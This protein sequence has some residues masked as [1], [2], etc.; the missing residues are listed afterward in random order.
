MNF[1]LICLFSPIYAYILRIISYTSVNFWYANYVRTDGSLLITLV[2]IIFHAKFP[3]L[4]CILSEWILYIVAR[5]NSVSYTIVVAARSIAVYTGSLAKKSVLACDAKKTKKR[6]LES[7]QTIFWDMC[8]QT[9]FYEQKNKWNLSFD[10]KSRVL[11]LA[12]VAHNNEV[13]LS[14]AMFSKNVLKNL[15]GNLVRITQS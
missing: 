13:C 5:E 4:I 9:I 8:L 1:P 3:Y 7:D 11:F 10:G 6:E 2:W 12:R 14:K 15:W